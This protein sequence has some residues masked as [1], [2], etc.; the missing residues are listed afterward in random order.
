MYKKEL[1]FLR[2]IL[3]QIHLNMHTFPST[4]SFDDRIDMGLRNFLGLKDDY[5]NY[6]GLSLKGIQPNTIYK[7]SDEFFCNYIIL[8]LPEQTEYKDHILTIGP[9]TTQDF[10]KQDIY[11][12]IANYQISPSLTARFFQYYGNI[13]LISDIT[14]LHSILTAFAETIWGESE[15]YSEVTISHFLEENYISTLPLQIMNSI[16]ESKDIYYE[17]QLLEMRYEAEKQFIKNISDGNYPKAELA[18]ESNTFFQIEKRSNDPIRNIKNYC[19]IMNTLL[20]KAAEYGY[21]HPL[22]IDRLSSTYAQKIET[23]TSLDSAKNL[24]KEMVR[25][26][27]L[28]VKNYSLKNYSLLVRKVI[29]RIDSDLAADQSL[30]AHA[31]LLNVSPSYL[32]TLFHK[33]TGRTLTEYVNHKRIEFSIFLLNTTNMQIQLISQHCG[34]SDINYF[35]KIFKKYIGKTPTEYRNSIKS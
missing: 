26:Y 23:L 20:R 11:E 28:L 2:K 16:S 8:A 14:S 13:P 27:G 4:D 1:E 5:M 12:K 32:S 9:Y 22:H 33:E 29:T 10:T 25:K 3:S 21:V 19:I 30:N 31:Q 6:F 35:I 17:M 18:L 34:F 15:N 7:V 24:M